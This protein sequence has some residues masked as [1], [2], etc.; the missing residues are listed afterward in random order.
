MPVGSERSRVEVRDLLRVAAVG[1]GDV[2][3]ELR[4][5]DERRALREQPLVVVELLARLRP[6][7]APD[8]LRAVRIEERAAVV[9]RRVREPLHVLAVGVHPIEL[10]VAVA[11]AREDDRAVLPADRRLGVVARRVGETHDVLAVAV[12]LEDVVGVVE[13]PDVAL[14]VIG[15]RRT[16][17][18]A[19]MG[20]GV[21]DLLV[22]RHEVR[23]RRRALAARHRDERRHGLSPSSLRQPED[24]RE[25]HPIDAIAVIVTRA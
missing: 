20:R 23:A 16:C 4:R 22:A 14:A 21:D 17:I 25:R 3:L 18:A 19:E 1:I 2:E 8:D 24:A 9:A 13:R 6:R 10:D 11:E 7:C 5:T 15:L 12:G